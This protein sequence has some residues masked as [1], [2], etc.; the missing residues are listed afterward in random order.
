MSRAH[1]SYIP[2]EQVENATD[3]NFSAVDQAAL[4]FAAKLKA[5]AIEEERAR[6]DTA[7]KSGYSEGHAAG[8]TEGYAEAKRLG[9]QQLDDYI[10]N[11]GQ[12]AAQHMAELFTSA[13]EQL[14]QSEQTIAKGV[15]ELACELARQVLRRELS[16]NP[17]VLQPVVREALGM[18]SID[19]TT[20]ALRL[21]PQD[22]DVLADDLQHAFSNLAITL[23][24]DHNLTPGGCLVEAA[25]TVIDGSVERRWGRAVA[26]LG[27]DTAWEQPTEAPNDLA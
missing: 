9:Q 10:A 11:Q 8:Y 24:P 20:A 2:A 26:A 18:L 25:G 6:D 19:H 3:W 27:L 7:R 15:L 14:A 12:Q 17:N 21:H 4:R 16:T 22:M 23:V 1:S 13:Q 5:Q